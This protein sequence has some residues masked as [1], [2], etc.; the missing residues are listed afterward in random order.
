MEL[1]FLLFVLMGTNAELEKA[2]AG[3]EQLN[4][5]MIELALENQEMSDDIKLMQADIEALKIADAEM[6]DSFIKAATSISLNHANIEHWK[7][8]NDEWQKRFE[9]D[10][11]IY[12]DEHSIDHIKDDPTE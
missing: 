5:E 4:S 11:E 12:K 2:T 7:N 8:K 1:A 6:E 9:L 10:F 3:L